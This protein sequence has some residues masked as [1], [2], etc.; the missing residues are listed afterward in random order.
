MFKKIFKNTQWRSFDELVDS[1]NLSN[2]QIYIDT[3]T[4]K[5]SIYID[6]VIRF[7]NNEDEK[8]QVLISKRKPIKI[9]INA[10]SGDQSAMFSLIDS[11]KLSR[12][13]IYTINTGQV[14][15][16]AFFVYLAGH[17]RYCYPNASFMVQ[18]LQP[19]SS[20]VSENDN[21]DDFFKKKLLNLKD[22]TIEKTKLEENEYNKKLKELWY[23]NA[24]EAQSLRICNE[25]ANYIIQF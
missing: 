17:K 16:E 19:I 4:P 24:Q 13:P 10:V 2:R 12:T 8:E 14:Y 5:V 1:V 25:I 9:Y 23:I 18:K 6:S 20:S 3:I 22:L 11:I 21:C 15:K 7:W